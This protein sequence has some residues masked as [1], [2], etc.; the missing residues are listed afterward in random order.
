MRH[1]LIIC[2][3]FAPDNA[4]AAV[5]ITK[6]AKYL[7]RAGYKV[8]VIK[9]RHLDILN[10]EILER[11]ADGA[12]VIY[13]ENT[14]AFKLF[15]NVYK[16][17]IQPLKSKR[18]NKLDNRVRINPQTG[19][20]EFYPFETAYPII[21]S[22]EYVVEQLRQMDLCH[23]IKNTLKIMNDCDLLFTSYGDSFSLHAGK[24]YHK[25][26]ANVPWVFDIRDAIVR[27][28]FTPNYVRF[29]PIS[30]ENYVWKNADAII[31]VSKGICK[32]VP[33]VYWKKTRCITNGYDKEDLSDI[34][35]RD[36]KSDKLVFS[37][38]GSMYG[39]LR[40]LSYFF[41]AVAELIENGSVEQDKIEF[42]FAGNDSA[43]EIFKSQADK[44]GLGKQCVTQGKLSRKES[45]QLQMDSNILLMASYD[46]QSHV[47]GVLTGKLMEY[48]MMGKPVIAIVT[49]DICRGEVYNTINKTAIGAALEESNEVED[50]PALR[51][52]ILEQYT[53][54][55]QDG[56]LKYNPNQPEL[57]KYDYK[58]TSRRLIKLFDTLCKEKTI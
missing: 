13:A 48:M 50:Y 57:N 9:E 41:K 16:K 15:H 38:T 22:I 20:N 49:G 14:L 5:R 6:F 23:S 35:R 39:G 2:N 28:K 19:H 17:I 4:I 31:G 36:I 56:K 37:Y 55:E 30:Y 47:G 52:Y 44:Y 45:M 8:T 58:Y 25:Y 21:G 1:V 43:Y 34:Q 27:Y 54:W 18:M 11:D 46:Y 51:N 10:D 40:D 53:A 12:E 29:I 42:C 33:K 32:R 24:K 26:H 3:Y 7:M